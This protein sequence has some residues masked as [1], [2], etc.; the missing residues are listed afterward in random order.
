LSN[1]VIRKPILIGLVMIIV[2]II[3][4][5]STNA[6]LNARVAS[7]DEENKSQSFSSAASTDEAARLAGYTVVT[8]GYLPPQFNKCPLITVHETNAHL[9]K[10]VMQV[11]NSGEKNHF[12]YLIQDPSLDG[13]GGGE[14]AEFGGIQ[15][16]RKYTASTEYRPSIL[17]LYWRDGDMAYVITGTLKGALNEDELSKIAAS[18]GIK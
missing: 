13:I 1:H 17:S 3:A 18:V 9:P 6:L 4:F 11:W 8:P 15:G 5:A 2:A 16:E 7:A 14:N 10:R 12:F